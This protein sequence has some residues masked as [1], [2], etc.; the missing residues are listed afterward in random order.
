MDNPNCASDN[1]ASLKNKYVG[2]RAF[3]I[4]NGP[5]LKEQ[6][7]HILRDEFVF[8]VNLITLHTEFKHFRKCYYCL[9]DPRFYQHGR[10]LPEIH[11]NIA[12]HT[13]VTCFFENRAREAIKREKKMGHNSIFFVEI[14]PLQR[15]W[16][17]RFQ[18]DL[19][20]KL[21]WGYSVVIDQCLPIAIYLGFNPIYLIGCDCD[22]GLDRETDDF[23]NAYFYNPDTIS[24]EYLA[25]LRSSRKL[26]D[27]FNQSGKIISSYKTVGS[28]CSANGIEVYNAG[29]GGKL[30]VF[31]RVQFSSLF[32]ERKTEK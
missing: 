8:A 32:M 15:C 27:Q 14:D 20:K 17:G 30:E 5:S 24:P 21:C 2:E 10:L 1:L 3:I 18:V 22:Y 7:L 19:E 29:V 9:G 13:G 25:S 28:Y 16:E 6:E 23:K 31:K 26:P 11:D 12:G 4:G